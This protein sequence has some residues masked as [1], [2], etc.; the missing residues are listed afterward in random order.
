MLVNAFCYHNILLFLKIAIK[1]FVITSIDHLSF[2]VNQGCYGLW[3][4]WCG[5]DPRPVLGQEDP[6]VCGACADCLP[7]FGWVAGTALLYP[8]HSSL[9]PSAF[10]DLGPFV[11]FLLLPEA[12]STRS[13]G[14]RCVVSSVGA[15][16]VVCVTHLWRLALD[17]PAAQLLCELCA[18]L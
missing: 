14:H 5:A 10:Q 9:T 6:G 15:Y 13:C 2:E 1:E 18:L 8:L 16:C 11:T 4:M 12:G 3:R 17:P 7:L